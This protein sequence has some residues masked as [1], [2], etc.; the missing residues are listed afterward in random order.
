MSDDLYG[1]PCGI[2]PFW[3]F[4]GHLMEIA[5]A[6]KDWMHHFHLV[7]LRWWHEG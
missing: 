2:S 4:A 7:D 1:I 3:Q 6:K 5:C